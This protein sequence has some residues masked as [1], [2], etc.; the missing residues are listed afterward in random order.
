MYKALYVLIATGNYAKADRIIKMKRFA[1]FPLGEKLTKIENII[2]DIRKLYKFY[3]YGHYDKLNEH[4]N[5]ITE[6]YDDFIDIIKFRLILELYNSKEKNDIIELKNKILNLF[7]RYPKEYEFIKYL[8]DCLY[9]LDDLKNAYKFYL[10]FNILSNNGLISLNVDYI[11]KDNILLF[12]EIS[13]S[14][15]DAIQKQFNIDINTND[16]FEKIK[17]LSNKLNNI[18]VY[19]SDT[20]DIL[21]SKGC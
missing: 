17:F 21:L 5:L 1:G 18:N 11:I 13:E 9:M 4:L 6:E 10:I 7:R 14:I 12:K 20:Y 15:F 16:I 8:A 19:I 2:A 3:V